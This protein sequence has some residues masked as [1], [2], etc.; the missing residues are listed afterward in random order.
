[1]LLRS[2][3]IMHKHIVCSYCKQISK[4]ICIGQAIGHKP[5]N[6]VNDAVKGIFQDKK[7]TCFMSMSVRLQDETYAPK[8]GYGHVGYFCSQQ[9]LCERGYLLFS[10][11]SITPGLL[12]PHHPR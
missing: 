12:M 9:G 2:D 11:C 7:K 3:Y 1:M 5:K 6:V 10:K 8:I 4:T